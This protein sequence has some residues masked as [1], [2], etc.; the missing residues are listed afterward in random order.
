MALI[1]DPSFLA[2]H[3]LEHYNDARTLAEQ[4]GKHA[5]LVANDDQ[6]IQHLRNLG[7]SDIA[8]GAFLVC[9]LLTSASLMP[10][11]MCVG[12]LMASAVYSFGGKVERGAS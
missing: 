5:C 10:E 11:G 7:W 2:A 8:I 3:T 12:G 1:D 9:D 4:D 6:A